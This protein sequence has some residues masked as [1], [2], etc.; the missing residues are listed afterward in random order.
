MAFYLIIIVTANSQKIMVS[1]LCLFLGKKEKTVAIYL[2]Y[3]FD[4]F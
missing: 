1:R 3:L 2:G 4:Y